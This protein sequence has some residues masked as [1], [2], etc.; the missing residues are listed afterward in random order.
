MCVCGNHCLNSCNVNITSGG[1]INNE[2]AQLLKNKYPQINTAK[3]SI[4]T[5]MDR[6]VT[7]V[8][9][10][11]SPKSAKIASSSKLI[12][13]DAAPNSQN[14]FSILEEVSTDTILKGKPS[15]PPPIYLREQNSNDLVKSLVE[16]T[17]ENSFYVIPIKRGKI[18]ETKIQVLDEN[19]FRKV[20]S[21][22]ESKKKVF[23]LTN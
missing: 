16:L 15:R 5:G 17:G 10:Q 19:N 12:K 2:S 9:R 6:Y 18:N 22:L 23:T 7:V 1:I 8:K 3:A 4:Q 11:R 21:V 13:D 14:R 20:V